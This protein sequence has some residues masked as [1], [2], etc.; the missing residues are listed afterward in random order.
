MLPLMR[1]V[2][3]TMLGISILAGCASPPIR[4][5]YSQDM[6]PLREGKHL[7]K[8]WFDEG[9]LKVNHYSEVQLGIVQGLGISNQTNITIDEAVRWLREATLSPGAD[10]VVLSTGG[11]GQIATLELV[12]TELNPGSTA[13][14]SGLESLVLARLGTG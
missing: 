9:L 13:A 4:S 1:T 14:R 7:D 5:D 8:V 12:I 3:L 10:A 2:I 6:Q 11:Q